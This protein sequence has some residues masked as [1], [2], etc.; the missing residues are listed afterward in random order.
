MLR[1]TCALIWLILACVNA[2]AERVFTFSGDSSGH[3]LVIED[4]NPQSKRA[5]KGIL[6]GK[7]VE[8]TSRFVVQFH[9]SRTKPLAFTNLTLEHPKEV[10]ASI[11]IYTFPS[12]L[13]ALE[14]IQKISKR[15]DVAVACPILRRSRVRHGDYASK[16]NDP[17]FNSQFSL[18][19]R[20]SSGSPLGADL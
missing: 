10:A 17:H 5:L 16:P 3:R 15:S 1:Y 12:A 13:E 11:F 20:A 18:E 19:N 8:I 14:E 2:F 9:P 6:N 7:S 4:E